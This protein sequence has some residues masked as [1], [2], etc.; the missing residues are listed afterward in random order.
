L[1]RGF[2]Q[3]HIER[4]AYSMVHPQGYTGRH[5]QG[6]IHL[7]REDREA[8][9]GLTTPLRISGKRA[10][11]HAGKRAWDHAGKRAW[12]HAGKRAWDHAGKRA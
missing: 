1:R 12:D 7:Q 11:D 5:I 2:S 4:V 8:Y 3:R 10:W 6:D 9:T